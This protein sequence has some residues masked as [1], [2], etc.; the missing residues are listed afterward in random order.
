MSDLPF[1]EFPRLIHAATD[2]VVVLRSRLVTLERD[3]KSRE[4]TLHLTT[5]KSLGDNNTTR[6]AAFRLFLQ[7]DPD[8]LQV[9]ADIDATNAALWRQDSEVKRLENEFLAR[10]LQYRHELLKA[11]LF[12]GFLMP[13]ERVTQ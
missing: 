7:S 12:G 9:Q 5:W 6:D 3:L 2:Q 13:D 10:R 1:A 4:D 8:Y 11:E